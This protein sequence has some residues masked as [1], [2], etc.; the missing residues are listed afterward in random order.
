MLLPFFIERV[1][2]IYLE[3]SDITMSEIQP[4]IHATK[5]LCLK[6]IDS[7]DNPGART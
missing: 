6:N 1:S 7:R 2:A 3:N 5:L 4:R